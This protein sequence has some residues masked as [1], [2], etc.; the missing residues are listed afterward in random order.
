MKVFIDGES[1]VRGS[2]E[3]APDLVRE[4][5]PEATRENVAKWLARYAEI[6]DC[7]VKLVF[8]ETRSEDVLPPTEEYGRVTV[9]NLLQ[10]EKVTREICKPANQ[11]A[12]SDRVFV[13]ADE[14]TVTEPVKS[15]DVRVYSPTEFIRRARK[16][17]GKEQTSRYEE[18]D[19]KY[20]GVAEEEVD[21]WMD[22]FSEKDQD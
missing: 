18:P 8:A 7:D 10:G 13:V 20:S 21:F 11:A 15:T 1:F 16:I 14:P 2:R 5:A 3:L 9:R 4:G 6:Q 22:Y 17:M 12:N 19:E